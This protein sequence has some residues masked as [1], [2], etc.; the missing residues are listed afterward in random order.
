MNTGL[1]GI[2]LVF[3]AYIVTIVVAILIIAISIIILIATSV[4]NCNT[5]ATAM[6]VLWVIIAALFLV[7]LLVV[8]A[9]ARKLTLSKEKRIAAMV[10]Y[11]VVLLASY[12][13]IAFGLMVAFNC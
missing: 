2:L 7:S 12:V 1:K 13:V 8:R 6:L 10:A 3:G 9:I 4:T 5:I 11:G